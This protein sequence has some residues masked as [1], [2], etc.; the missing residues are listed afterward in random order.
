MRGSPIRQLA[1]L[2]LFGTVA[3]R[4]TGFQA[5]PGPISSADFY[6]VGGHGADRH[7]TD[8]PIQTRQGIVVHWR[9]RQAV[10]PTGAAQWP[11]DLT[12]RREP[13]CVAIFTCLPGYLK[14]PPD[15]AGFRSHP[16]PSPLIFCWVFVFAATRIRTENWKPG[17]H[18][19]FVLF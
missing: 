17:H 16:L 3:A 9:L 11:F 12:D 10:P 5:G 19:F 8:S 13:Q 6:T 14:P 4:P 18:S 2:F 15:C 7:R 1:W